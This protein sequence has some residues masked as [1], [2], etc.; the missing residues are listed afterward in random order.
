[1]EKREN[2]VGKQASLRVKC[3]RL[4]GN[5]LMMDQEKLQKNRKPFTNEMIVTWIDC[6]ELI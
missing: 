4:C 3:L 2:I 5:I 1:M 6:K